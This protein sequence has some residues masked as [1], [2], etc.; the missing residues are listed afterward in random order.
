[1]KRILRTL[2]TTAL[3]AFAL[4][5]AVA[6]PAHAQITG[7]SNLANP[8]VPGTIPVSWTFS[9]LSFFSFGHSLA[10]SF[11]TGAGSAT[12]AGV[13]LA[14][15]SLNVVD[16]GGFTVSLYGDTGGVPGSLI[17]LLSG[18]STPNPT[19]DAFGFFDYTP[20]GLTS[21]TEFT[22][23]WIVAEVPHTGANKQYSWSDTGDLTETGEPGWSMGAVA[24]RNFLD[25]NLQPWRPNPDFVL[26]ME[27]QIAAAQ[28]V[29]EASTWAAGVAM[30]LVAGAT[31]R[32]QRRN[33]PAA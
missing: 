19:P 1:M 17:G 32:R 9:G 16:G 27:V 24:S 33:R 20:Q 25:G 3:P 7:V 28:E 10:Q 2:A 14:M 12:L 8:D 30:S 29:P 4:A 23:Y 31:W 22:P 21:L 15:E 26:R 13:S 18:D 5:F 6:T 11:T